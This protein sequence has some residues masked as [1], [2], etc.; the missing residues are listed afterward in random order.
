L[1]FYKLNL[2]VKHKHVS[3]VNLSFPK[4][5]I[6]GDFCFHVCSGVQFRHFRDVEK[7]NF[8]FRLIYNARSIFN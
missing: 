5:I 7:L 4:R 2:C 8:K 3:Y 1:N 6:E